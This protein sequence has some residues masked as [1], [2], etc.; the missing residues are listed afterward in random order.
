MGGGGWRWRE[1]KSLLMPFTFLL[2]V[3]GTFNCNFEN[4]FCGWTQAHD[5][6]F[7]WT[8]QSRPTT[9]TNTG[10]S[11][12]HTTGR[13]LYTHITVVVV[14]TVAVAVASNLLSPQN[15]FLVLKPE[16][17]MHIFHT[18]LTCDKTQTKVETSLE[19]QKHFLSVPRYD[20]SAPL[21]RPFF[22]LFVIHGPSHYSRAARKSTCHGNEVL[23]QDITHLILRPFYQHGSLCQDP[24]GNC[25]TQRPPDHHKKMQTMDISP[26]HWV[27]PKPSCKAQ[28]KGEENKADRERWEGNIKEW[29]GLEFGKSQRAVENREKLRKLVAKSSVV[30]QRPWQSR[31]WWWWWWLALLICL[32][33]HPTIDLAVQQW[34]YSEFCV[35]FSESEMLDHLSA[36]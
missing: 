5:D 8:R 29:T 16:T 17:A 3:P 31:N 2:P 36:V 27:W 23:Q 12:D 4:N 1:T 26:V 7:D 9:T 28:W 33:A 25:T 6:Q 20:K 30:H 22:C 35:D 21:S 24:A 14:V 10:P 19:W 32:L 18:T 34:W 13:E 11:R 15:S